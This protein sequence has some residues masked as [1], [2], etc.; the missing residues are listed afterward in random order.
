MAEQQQQ[1]TKTG[2]N[3]DKKSKEELEKEQKEAQEQLSSIM[4]MHKKPKNLQ[5][6]LMN[7]VSNIVA[8]A[9]GGLGQ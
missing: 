4:K 1:Q 2:E 7:G 6:G 9:V 5:Q 8:G 3:D